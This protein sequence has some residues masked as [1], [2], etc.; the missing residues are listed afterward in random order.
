MSET[1][2]TP[3]PPLNRVPG[4][5][6]KMPNLGDFV[7]RRLPDAFILPWD[8][9]LQRGLASAQA[10]LGSDWLA[11]Y[12]V[13][14]VH[15]FW[16]APGVLGDCAWA[17]VLMP[18]VDAVGRYFPL[19]VA[20]PIVGECSLDQVLGAGDWFDALDGAARRVL[21][22]EF[23]A[24]DFD[25]ALEAIGPTLG[26]APCDIDEH[27]LAAA[28]LANA[29]GT[30]PLLEAP[31]PCSIWWSSTSTTVDDFDVF[32]ALPPADALAALLT[33]GD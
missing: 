7:S 6:G 19:T 25:A 12:L 17:G 20:L 27:E 18:S 23:R 29:D 10:E 30:A 8:D 4:W 33:A 11:R 3:L 1:T 21:D 24:A 9:W 22:V 5:F 16:L 13:A 14:P 32:V 26:E 2:V 15:R 28:L 31:H